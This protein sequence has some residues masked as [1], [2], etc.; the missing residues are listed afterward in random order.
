M[1]DLYVEP[2][3]YDPF[4]DPH[5]EKLAEISEQMLAELIKLREQ[6]ERI[7]DG[8]EEQRALMDGQRAVYERVN[9]TI[10]AALQRMI[11]ALQQVT[12]AVSKPRRIRLKREADGSASEAISE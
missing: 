1:P 9:A 12:G 10:L 8:V 7:A 11:E 3:D 6:S 4:S 5:I 2:V